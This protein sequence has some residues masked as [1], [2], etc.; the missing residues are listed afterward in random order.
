MDVSWDDDSSEAQFE[1]V[2][3]H[4]S[5][6]WMLHQCR[7]VT[8]TEMIDFFHDTASKR[9][10]K[11]NNHGQKSQRRVH[12]AKGSENS[13]EEHQILNS[14][15]ETNPKV[16]DELWCAPPTKVCEQMNAVTRSLT[17]PQP[18]SQ[19]QNQSPV[20]GNGKQCGGISCA[21]LTHS[22]ATTGGGAPWLPFLRKKTMTTVVQ[23]KIGP[24]FQRCWHLEGSVGSTMG[25]SCVRL[26][27]KLVELDFMWLT[28]NGVKPFC[29][30]QTS[31]ACAHLMLVQTRGCLAGKCGVWSSALCLRMLVLLDM[32]NRLETKF[33][34]LPTLQSL[35]SMQEWGAVN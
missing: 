27:H 31:K 33:T 32:T 30:A 26:H 17:R 16:P 14:G 2:V 10:Q 24:L 15:T 20:P 5:T 19:Q 22:D 23:R 34:S 3:N 1:T 28:L 11:D 18:P 6:L 21:N 29:I 8:F 13:E 9:M 35:G 7:D 12:F 25:V 4:E